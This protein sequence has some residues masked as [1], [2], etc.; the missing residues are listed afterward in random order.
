MI[1]RFISQYWLCR[2]KI[3]FF[4]IMTR[5]YIGHLRMKFIMLTTIKMPTVVG[6]LT[7]ISMINIIY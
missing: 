7:S 6:M 1:L 5:G 2:E 3:H 4:A